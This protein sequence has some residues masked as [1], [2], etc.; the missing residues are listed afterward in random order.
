MRTYGRL[1]IN[2]G[3]LQWVTITTAP[4]GD[5]SMIW[6]V[7]LCQNLLLN[8]NE[9]PF[10]ADRGLPAHQSVIQQVAPDTYVSLTQ[11]RF[12]PYFASLIIFRQSA[13]PPTY[14]V[15]VTTLQGAQLSGVVTTA[16]GIVINGQVPQ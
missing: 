7:T 16:S 5:N 4:S 3:P 12:A 11:Q 2:G 6:L 15:N 8:L 14:Q 13:N 9:S 10:Y 1:S